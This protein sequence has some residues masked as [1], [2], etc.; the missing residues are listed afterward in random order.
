MN[1]RMKITLSDS[2][3]DELRSAAEAGGEPMARLAARLIS[4]GLAA[5][6]EEPKPEPS[7]PRADR[8]TAGGHPSRNR[9]ARWVEPF[10]NELEWRR[11]M[12][13]AIVALRERYPRELGHLKDE[14]WEHR[15]H[16]ET[17][18]ALAVWRD[19]IDQA[20]DDPREE[21]VFHSQLEEYGRTLRQEGGGVSAAWQP[22]AP[23]TGWA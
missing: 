3:T 12:W 16:V 22:D 7:R 18:C 11:D 5:G 8:D 14:W 15:A 20:A 13:A 9:R 2:T 4:A 6:G 21:L 10:E 17:L 1:H 19:W 23:P